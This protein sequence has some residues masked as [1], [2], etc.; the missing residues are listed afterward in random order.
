MNETT[1]SNVPIH[2]DET[3]IFN[4]SQNAE[5]TFFVPVRALTQKSGV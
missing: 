1:R 2:A 5:N 4:N 3:I